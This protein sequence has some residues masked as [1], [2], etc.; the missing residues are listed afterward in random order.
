M[1]KI[2][3]TNDINSNGVSLNTLFKDVERKAQATYG[4]DRGIF[5]AHFN[6]ALGYLNTKAGLK[7]PTI[8]IDY[9]ND[10]EDADAPFFEGYTFELGDSL[11]TVGEFIIPSGIIY[12]YFVDYLTYLLDVKQDEEMY[13]KK[14]W[15]DATSLVTGARSWLIS[16]AP[17]AYLDLTKTRNFERL[18]N[19]I[20]ASNFTLG[21]SLL[22]HLTNLN[23]PL[24]NG[25]T[26][27]RNK[28]NNLILKKQIAKTANEQFDI[29]E[30]GRQVS[31]WIND[32]A[33]A[34]A[35]IQDFNTEFAY[36]INIGTIEVQETI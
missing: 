15:Q 5:T 29:G 23:S 17:I 25:S 10:S 13:Y 24:S 8:T 36:H 18:E 1:A 34:D 33:N 16:N 32:D 6:Q 35:T 19:L 14:H 31:A 4:G 9:M 28:R 22:T 2:E 27:S 21:N 20:N 12:T 3:N 7:I 30:V 26:L 11:I